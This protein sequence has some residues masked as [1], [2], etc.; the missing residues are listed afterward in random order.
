MIIL[1]TLWSVIAA[2]FIMSNSDLV[3][4]ILTFALILVAN[5]PIMERRFCSRDSRIPERKY[6]RVCDG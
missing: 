4:Y 1:P 2:S 6:T 5:K 3:R